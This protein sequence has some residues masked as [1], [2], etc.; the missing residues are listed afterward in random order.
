V[1]L[2]HYPRPVLLQRVQ[3]VRIPE[4]QEDQMTDVRLAVGSDR[5]KALL[6]FEAEWGNPILVRG[7]R[8]DFAQC[9]ILIAG[10]FE[11]LAAFC[12]RDQPI[13]ELV[14]INAFVP[15]RG[16]GTALLMALR[17]R[18]GADFRTLW[19]ATTNDNVIA[20]S[21]YQSRGFRL[22]ALRL[23]AVDEA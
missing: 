21:F 5:A 13:A 15:H 23:G 7:E 3:A 2:H 16:I 8:Y 18:L 4:P 19:V 11:G 9:E 10:D 1:R 14:A 12:T 17:N 6:R 22:S 20:L